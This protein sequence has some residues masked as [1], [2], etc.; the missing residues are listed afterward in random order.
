[1][2]IQYYKTAW[3]DI[4]NSPGW[5]GKVC[6]L[7][8]LNLIPIFG[9]IV[10]LGYLYGWAR[11]IAWGTRAPM[12]RKI[13]NNDDGKFW[14]RGW[15]IL[16]LVFVFALV[17]S[18]ISGIGSALQTP[19]ITVTSSGV[20]S[21]NVNPMLAGLG[22][23]LYLVGLVGS[24][25][26]GILAWIGSVRIAIYDRLSPGFQ[27]NKIWKMFRHDTSGIMRIFGMQ[28]L[29]GFILGIILS[30]VIT[31]LFTLAIFAG[32]SGLAAA[33]YTA[34]SLQHLTQTQAMHVLMQFVTSAGIVGIIA[35]L[36]TLFLSSAAGVFVEM[37]VVRAVGYWTMQFNVPQWRGQD[38]PMPF[39]LVPPA[40]SQPPVN[41]TVD[42]QA[43]MQAG[44]PQAT[45]Q[46]DAPY[47]AQPVQ[48][49]Y[50]PA[51]MQQPTQQ[52]YAQPYDGASQMQMGTA[53]ASA[54]AAAPVA[55]A[56]VAAEV[57][58]DIEPA[59]AV[60]AEPPV[61]V[62][63]AV[64][65]APVTE[66]PANVSTAEAPTETLPEAPAP[67]DLANEGNPTPPPAE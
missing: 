30:I 47:G 3:G 46:Y 25:L 24:L 10:T 62:T 52:M 26:C 9:Q 38:D 1:M 59:A 13:F 60:A 48:N 40:A 8:L 64:A 43:P 22:S 28:L 29:F 20:H 53:P 58:A 55:A 54:V 37:L 27:F 15:F 39:E 45:T 66:A 63:P 14:R 31:I 19:E 17:P 12:S 56:A 23:V 6:L 33:G 21:A 34:E 4:K 41:Q 32:I 11:E 50:Q 57:P 42:A 18:I 67:T 36:L 35:V 49:A 7:A 61:D 2:N 51:P 65:E 44:A 5:F 16:V